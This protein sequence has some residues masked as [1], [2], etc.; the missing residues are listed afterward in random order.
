MNLSPVFVAFF[1][2]CFAVF[3]GVVWEFY[4]FTAD[5]I[6]HTTCRSL[7]WK[8]GNLWWAARR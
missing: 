8:A 5:G 7:P 6:L 1:A 2:L 3:L 4:E